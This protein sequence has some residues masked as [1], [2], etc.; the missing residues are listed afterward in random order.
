VCIHYIGRIGRAIF[1]WF[2]G[3]QSLSQSEQL[4]VYLFKMSIIVQSHHLKVMLMPMIYA[5][6]FVTRKSE[7]TNKQKKNDY[8]VFYEH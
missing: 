3:G 4:L 6:M 7:T 1:L 2:G 8:P 5:T